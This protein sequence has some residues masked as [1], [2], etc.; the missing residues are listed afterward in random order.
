M[1]PKYK[2]LTAETRREV[3]V[4][5]AKN[6]SLKVFHFVGDETWEMA[7]Q[8]LKALSGG[9]PFEWLYGHL[10]MPDQYFIDKAIELGLLEKIEQTKCQ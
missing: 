6:G 3:G 1:I 4:Y 5:C 9:L 10:D 7:N 2:I 8:A